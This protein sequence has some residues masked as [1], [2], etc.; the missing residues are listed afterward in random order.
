[1]SNRFTIHADGFATKTSATYRNAAEAAFKLA[2]AYIGSEVTIRDNVRGEIA[3][4]FVC[5]PDGVVLPA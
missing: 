4:R 3:E 1:M 5:H 2:K